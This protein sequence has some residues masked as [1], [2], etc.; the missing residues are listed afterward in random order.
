[1]DGQYWGVVVLYLLAYMYKLITWE[2]CG[3]VLELVKKYGKASAP[4]NSVKRV[5]LVLSM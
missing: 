3:N 2:K 4:G 1:M 5:S